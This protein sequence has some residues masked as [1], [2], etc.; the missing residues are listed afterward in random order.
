MVKAPNPVVFYYG[1]ASKRIQDWNDAER[2]L[3]WRGLR[4]GDPCHMSGLTEM[5]SSRKST[6]EQ[7]IYWASQKYQV[8]TLSEGFHFLQMGA[9]QGKA[10]VAR[11]IGGTMRV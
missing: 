11:A 8:G 9:S 4:V 3:W 7:T 10:G 1:S 6:E 2:I 5:N